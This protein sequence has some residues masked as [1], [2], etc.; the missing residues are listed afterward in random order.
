MFFKTFALQSHSLPLP[1][2]LLF[3]SRLVSPRPWIAPPR[4]K[5]PG[6]GPCLKS[7]SPISKNRI[8]RLFTSFLVLFVVLNDIQFFELCTIKLKGGFSRH[9]VFNSTSR[10]LQSSI[11]FVQKVCFAFGKKDQKNTQYLSK[12]NCRY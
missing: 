7:C 9:E 8:G 4:K 6:Y 10:Y 11:K 5:K 1:R 2:D 12:E 3:R